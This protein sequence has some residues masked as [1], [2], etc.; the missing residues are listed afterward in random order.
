VVDDHP[1]NRK[2]LVKQ[3]ELLGIAADTAVDGVEALAMWRVG[4]YAAVLADIHMPRMDGYALA[5]TIR[6]DEASAPG[7]AQRTPLIA[8]TANA[9][10]GEE[11]RCLAA[12][13]DAYL[14]KPV[15]FER[16]RAA[17]SRWLPVEPDE[18]EVPA[19]GERPA[20]DE[21]ALRA[22]L[23]DDPDTVAELLQDFLR[24]AR[25]A[26][27]DIGASLSN[28]NLAA[29][30]AM[31]HRLKGSALAIGARRLAEVA[32][33]LERAGRMGDRA[34]CQDGLGALA[35]E[36]RRVAVEIGE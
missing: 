21:S 10:R 18:G 6:R 26:E 3:L 19:T 25:E 12:G 31:A 4:Q 9:M 28:A 8:V 14:A 20:I 1:V 29:V 27:R 17:L 34:G 30:A 35:R 24:D 2:V 22:W 13:M 33:G 23:G 16:L 36:L 7:A 32:A 15:T 5:G 11:E